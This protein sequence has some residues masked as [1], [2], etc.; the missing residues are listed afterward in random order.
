MN[1]DS[2]AGTDK[3]LRPSKLIGVKSTDG[4]ALETSV[5]SSDDCCFL[6]DVHSLA[7]GSCGEICN[8]REDS[9][10][11]ELL[12]VSGKHGVTAHGFCKSHRSSETISSVD[13]AEQGMWMEWGPSLDDSHALGVQEDFS[14]CSGT[15]QVSFGSRTKARW[16]RP[17][18]PVEVSMNELAPPRRWLR[19]FFSKVETVKSE[20]YLFSRLPK[21]HSFPSSAK[22]VSFN[23]FG[24]DSTLLDLLIH[25]SSVLHGTKHPNL[26]SLDLGNNRSTVSD[27]SSHSVSGGTNSYYECFLV[28]SDNSH[29]LIG[30][31]L[32]LTDPTYQNNDSLPKT[33]K[34]KVIVAIARLVSWA[35]QWISLV[36]L[37]ESPDSVE[38]TDFKLSNAHLIC[39]NNFGLISFYNAMTGEFVTS[40]DLLHMGGFCQCLMSLKQENSFTKHNEHNLQEDKYGLSHKPTAEC[41]GKRRFRSLVIVSH[42]SL[43][44]AIDEFGAVYVMNVDD[45]I[46]GKPTKP[47]LQQFSHGVLAG[48]RV[49]GTEIGCQ[50]GLSDIS[51][52]QDT[53]PRT[54]RGFFST[55]DPQSNNMQSIQENDLKNQ[56]GPFKFYVSGLS[57][58]TQVK[59]QQKFL[60][61]ELPSHFMR[62]FFLPTDRTNE[63]EVICF[64]PFGITRLLRKYSYQKKRKYQLVHSSLLMDFTVKDNQDYPVRGWEAP[65]REAIGCTFQGCLY[66]VTEDGLSVVLPAISVLSSFLPVDAIGY[67]QLSS[68]TGAKYEA[69]NLLGID[70]TGKPWSPWKVEVLDRVLLYEGAEMADQLCLEN[71]N[72]PW[73]SKSHLSF[74]FFFKINL[75]FMLSY[76]NHY[77]I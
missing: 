59:N 46:L 23:I 42:S 13:I 43:I 41:T 4:F 7:W 18:P 37:D 44:G 21:R 11:R 58:V 5:D 22:V 70:L 52:V 14:S 51:W 71:G 3:F 36:M 63:D 45:H 76:F 17:R 25:G 19:T 77:I 16:Q 27:E 10:F 15:V 35:M 54:S 32:E 12:F 8:Q 38:W 56:R 6:S 66:L 64:S 39:L 69:D 57:S 26:S 73:S 53:L 33:R 40:V 2:A 49:G 67:R 62:K 1:A 72:T 65:I 60:G 75:I 50:R 61:S 68:T 55:V 28:F 24:H 74:F 34:S 31:A 29:C 9:A 48:W 30:F 47:Y 20:G